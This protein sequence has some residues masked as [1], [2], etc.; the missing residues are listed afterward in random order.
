M[1]NLASLSPWSSAVCLGEYVTVIGVADDRAAVRRADGSVTDASLAV[2]LAEG[3]Q[4]DV[5]DTVMVSI[6]MV[7]HIGEPLDQN[8]ENAWTP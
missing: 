7:L 4:V 6:G 5:G 8:V 3:I 1:A 2:L